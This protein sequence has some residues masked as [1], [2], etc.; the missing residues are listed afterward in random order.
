MK[1]LCE[2]SQLIHFEIKKPIKFFCDTLA[3][4]VGFL[5]HIIPIAKNNL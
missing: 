5:V 3:Y 4:K 2:D 1:L